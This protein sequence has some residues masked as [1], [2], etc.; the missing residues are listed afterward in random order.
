MKV[1]V[2]LPF[3]FNK[4]CI[5]YIFN[6]SVNL[7]CEMT[8]INKTNLEG[9]LSKIYIFVSSGMNRLTI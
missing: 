2:F 4:S 1:V 8:P 7:A 3:F 5:G 9:L 6:V